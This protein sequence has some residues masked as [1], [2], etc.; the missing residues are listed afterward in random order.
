MAKAKK[1][2]KSETVKRSKEPT[3]MELMKRKHD[4]KSEVWN[5][6]PCVSTGVGAYWIELGNML[7]KYPHLFGKSEAGVIIKMARKAH[8][9]E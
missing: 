1:K 5:R 7:D 2:A 9:K 3:K 4:L 8:E 6:C